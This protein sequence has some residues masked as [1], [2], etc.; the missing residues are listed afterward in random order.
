[1]GKIGQKLIRYLVVSEHYVSLASIYRFE[2][3]VHVVMS[4]A[5]F[6]VY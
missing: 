6:A 2:R 5:Y 1:M 4:F 3:L